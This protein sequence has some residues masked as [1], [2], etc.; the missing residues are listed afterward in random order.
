MQRDVPIHPNSTG[1]WIL[2]DFGRLYTVQSQHYR[3]NLH[4]LGRQA[5]KLPAGSRAIISVHV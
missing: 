3:L 1:T 5:G 4:R 2:S